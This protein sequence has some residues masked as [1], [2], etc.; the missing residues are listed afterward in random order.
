VAGEGRREPP[1]GYQG[2]RGLSKD[3]VTQ[4]PKVAKKGDL[5]QGKNYN[6]K[7]GRRGRGVQWVNDQHECV[8]RAGEESQ[9]VG[10]KKG[11][12]PPG[13]KYHDKF[14]PYQPKR[15]GT[16]IQSIANPNSKEP[17]QVSEGGKVGKGL[18]I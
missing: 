1:S 12:R 16:R 6:E 3:N 18:S 11:R 7:K 4:G 2:A 15:G 5:N 10:E 9:S 17:T 13:K 14:S 8:G